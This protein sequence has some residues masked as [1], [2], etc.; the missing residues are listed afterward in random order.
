MSLNLEVANPSV[1][2]RQGVPMEPLTHSFSGLMCSSIFLVILDAKVVI[3]HKTVRSELTKWNGIFRDG[4]RVCVI[5][6]T[7]VLHFILFIKFEK[8]YN[9]KLSL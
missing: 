1:Q 4:L 7:L 9:L 5:A 8:S 2:W 6:L 3:Y